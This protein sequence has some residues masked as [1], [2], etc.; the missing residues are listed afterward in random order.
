MRAS[1]LQSFGGPEVLDVADVPEP[2][3]RPGWSVVRLRSAGLNWHDTL[4]RR[5]VYS[6]PLP[7]IIGA[8]GAGI[9]DSGAHAGDEVVILPSLFWGRSQAAPGADFEI[10]GDQRNGTYAELAQVP[11]ECVFARPPGLSWSQ[12]GAFSLV[13]VTVFRALFT[14]GRLRTG[15][16]LLVLGASGGV[17]SFAIQLA[18]AA[19]VNV[20]ATSADARKRDGARDIGARSTI[21]HSAE[22]WTTQARSEANSG[23]GFDLVLDSVGRVG[24]SLD[25]LRPGGRCVVLG[26]SASDTLAVPLRP[27]YFS[28]HE[29]IGTTMGSPSDMRGLLKLIDEVGPMAPIID[30][31]FGLDEVVRAHERLESGQGFGK[32]TLEFDT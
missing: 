28:Q 6:S 17:S 19:G 24:E 8:D 25:C 16:S 13:G 21:D 22:D 10:L 32:I 30:S 3:P 27:F 11:D 31:H 1:L 20:T 2:T 15:E 12:A 9:I 5:G 23:E 4:V 7:I 14:R 26:A 29:I 18:A